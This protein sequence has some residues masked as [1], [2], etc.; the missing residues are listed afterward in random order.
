MR[1]ENVVAGATSGISSSGQRGV[2]VAILV[3]SAT[4][5]IDRGGVRDSYASADASPPDAVSASA[6]PRRTRDERI[7]EVERTAAR[8]VSLAGRHPLRTILV[9]ELAPE[10]LADQRLRQLAAELDLVGNLVT[11]EF[12]AAVRDELLRR[13]GLLGL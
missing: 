4:G 10:D 12:G 11:G 5:T 1:A 8:S 6:M 13:R 3:G 7:T 2:G 9:G